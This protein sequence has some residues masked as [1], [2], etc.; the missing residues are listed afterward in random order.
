MSKEDDWRLLVSILDQRL[1]IEANVWPEP[2]PARSAT[3]A[4]EHSSDAKARSVRGVRLFKTS[5]KRLRRFKE[6]ETPASASKVRGDDS[7]EE[8]RGAKL[9][10]VAASLDPVSAMAAAAFAK[11]AAV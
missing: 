4:S 1:S 9:M 10:E 8:E 6:R 5:R 2:P 7:S 11:P 3:A